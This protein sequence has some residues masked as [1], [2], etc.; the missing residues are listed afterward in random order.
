MTHQRSEKSPGELAIAILTT[1]D[2]YIVRVEAVTRA[3]VR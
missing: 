1:G 3:V 2:M